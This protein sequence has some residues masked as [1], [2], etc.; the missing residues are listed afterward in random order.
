MRR[1]VVITDEAP[2]I[3]YL[4][5][6][7]EFAEATIEGDLLK[8]NMRSQGKLEIDAID[9]KMVADI[10]FSHDP[11]SEIIKGKLG[12]KS[13]T[14]TKPE[15]PS[16]SDAKKDLIKALKAVLDDIDDE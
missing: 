6:S 5:S 9:P 11:S 3:K 7:W 15:T 14:Y 16:K 12:I 2:E 1:L 4:W 8:I 13:V 10:V